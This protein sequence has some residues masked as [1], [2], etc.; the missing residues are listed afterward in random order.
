MH[1]LRVNNRGSSIPRMRLM[2]AVDN[3][4]IFV[5]GPHVRVLNP[6]KKNNQGKSQRERERDGERLIEEMDDEVM[7]ICS[8]TRTAIALSR[9][10]VFWVLTK[11]KIVVTDKTLYN[12]ITSGLLCTDVNWL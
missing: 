7:R 9:F 6:N 8:G 5:I 2:V 4:R 11:L 12:D 3:C 10:I 1:K